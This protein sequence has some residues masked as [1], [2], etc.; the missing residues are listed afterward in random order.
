VATNTYVAE[1]STPQLSTIGLFSDGDLLVAA[2]VYSTSTLPQTGRLFVIVGLYDGGLGVATLIRDFLSQSTAP[3]WVA[4]QPCLVKFPLYDPSTPGTLYTFQGTAANGA[5]GAGNQTL[6][7]AAPA[8]GRV[9]VPAFTI[10]NNDT[11]SRAVDAQ[12]LDAAGGNLLR[13]VQSQATTVTGEI[14][15][16]PSAVPPSATG[17]FGSSGSDV[18]IAGADVLVLRVLAVAASQA[19]AYGLVMLVYGGAPTLTLAG[20]STPV[21]TTNTSRFEGG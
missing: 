6:T 21:L 10:T 16:W 2:S 1:P 20:A 5:G 17:S 12:L 7:I 13:L 19:S 14:V 8:G 9:V 3:T 18:V 4:G 15:S 11:I